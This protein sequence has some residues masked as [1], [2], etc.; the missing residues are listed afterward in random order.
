M[1]KLVIGHIVKPQGTKGEVKV[2]PLVSDP[3]WFNTLKYIYFEGEDK[4]IK[5]LSVSV[6]FG[7]AYIMLEGIS[8]MTAAETLRNK[9]ICVP[10]SEAPEVD[11]GEYFIEDLVDMKL[12]TESGQFLGRI[13]EVNN[14]GAGDVVTAHTVLGEVDF[15]FLDD[16]VLDVCVAT[17]TMTVNEKKFRE[18][19]SPDEV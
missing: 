7:W 13:K 6:R 11:E 9:H 14:Y 12:V 15:L 3:E 10:K 1:D 16:I 5:V 4:R 2:R 18:A 8:D 17:E 19:A